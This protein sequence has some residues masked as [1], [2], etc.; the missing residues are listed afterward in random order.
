MSPHLME[1]AAKAQ[2]HDRLDFAA[3]RR[4][5]TR[6]RARQSVS[7]ARP[8]GPRPVLRSLRAVFG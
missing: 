8:S 7:A 5:A 6:T 3:R 2:I 4:V 1:S